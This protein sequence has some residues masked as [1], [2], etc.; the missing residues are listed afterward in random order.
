MS[1]IYLY[2]GEEKFRI[3]NKIEALV[4]DAN[5][6][7]YNTTSYDMDELS[8][9]NAIQDALTLPFMSNK[10]VV[11]IKNPRFLS[12]EKNL[13]E[14]EARAFLNF[15]NRPMDTTVFII[16]AHNIKLDER[17][18]IVKKLK[19]VAE[20]SE[21]KEL[22]EIELIGWLKRQCAINNVEI[23]DDAIKH[24]YHIAGKNLTNAKNEVDKL[25]CYVGN[26][27]VITV[28]IINRV[29]VKEIQNDVF[30]LSNAIIEQNK[31]KIINLYRDLIKLGNDVNYLF[32]LV[33]KTMRE[34]L[35]VNIMLK[36]GYKQA[37]V[38]T[39]MN[40][41]NGRA[42]YLVKNARSV[43]LEKTE[44]YIIKLGELDYKIK[45]GLLDS[46]TGFEFFLF[47]L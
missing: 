19:K 18:E 17:K 38:A 9:F 21:N 36:E 33:S 12:S 1:S 25:I 4:K 28:D 34:L 27:G 40:V 46:K 16:N 42:Y 14:D 44:S 5:V 47:E 15:L 37:D 22:T 11:I 13:N 32:S 35:V 24:F 39:S 20:I 7:E 2:L 26:N 29:V 3:N 43:D 45:S 23:K 30:A 6:D 41:S 8:I 31:P 10:K